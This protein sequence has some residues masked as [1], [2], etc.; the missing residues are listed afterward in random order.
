MI[1]RLGGGFLASAFLHL[2]LFAGAFGFVAWKDAHAERSIDIDLTGSSLLMRPKNASGMARPALPPQPWILGTKGHAA[3]PPVPQAQPLSPVAEAEA[4][5]ACPPPCP[6]V[7]GD[8]VP[9]AATSRKPSW[10]DG[11]ITEDDY[12]PELRRKGVEGK[13]VVEVQ[14]DATGAVRGVTLEQ[15]SDPAFNTLVLERLK[16]SKFRPAYDQ[17]GNPVACRLRLPLSFKLRN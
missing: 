12:P 11:M 8:W 4:G 2:L 3:P 17:D 9:A 1:K 5:P 15:A 14:I 13:V 6:E 16:A 10:S 7:A